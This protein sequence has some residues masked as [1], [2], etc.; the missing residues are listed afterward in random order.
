MS[1]PACIIDLRALFCWVFA[2]FWWRVITNDFA[3]LQALVV[4]ALLPLNN[5]PFK[6][7][8]CYKI[9]MAFFFAARF[10]TSH[11]PQLNI[12]ILMFSWSQ[13][14][15][16]IFSRKCTQTKRCPIFLSTNGPNHYRT[17]REY[18][19]YKQWVCPSPELPSRRKS[20]AKNFLDQR[21]FTSG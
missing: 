5:F 4:S 15:K 10:F 3:L 17:A 1:L 2:L 9:F 20:E 14:S 19:V 16:T 21:W 11:P 12:L 7:Y 8:F 6:E 18:M 13:I